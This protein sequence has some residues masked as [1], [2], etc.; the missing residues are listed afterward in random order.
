M[1][2]R[3]RAKI[4]IQYFFQKFKNGNSKQTKNNNLIIQKSYFYDFSLLHHNS[5]R[6]IYFKKYISQ[7][8]VS[9]KIQRKNL[10]T[11]RSQKTRIKI[12]K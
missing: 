12:N 2:V 11:Y 9:F 1:C 7:R 10:Q 5:N 4:I 3:K 8:L 6:K